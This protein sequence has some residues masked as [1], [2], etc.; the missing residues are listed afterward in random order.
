MGADVTQ[1]GGS[2][3]CITHGVAKAVSIRMAK[4]A[5]LEWYLDS[6][7]NQLSPLDKSMDV[8]TNANFEHCLQEMRS[9]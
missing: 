9:A 1:S 5:K 3:Q 8:V 6:A 7:Q 4:Q 2:E